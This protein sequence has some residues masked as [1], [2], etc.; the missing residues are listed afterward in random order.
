M[1][2]SSFRTTELSDA[3]FELGNLRFI[4]VKTSNLLGRG[5]ICVYVPPDETL[6]NLPIYILLHGVYGSAWIW[7]FK[8][9]AHHTA[10]RLIAAGE[11]RPAI[12]AMPSDGLWGDGSAYLT[13][14]QKNFASWIV[15]DV[16]K[17]VRELIP[18]AGPNSPLCIGG[19]SMGGFGALMLGGMHPEKFKAVSAHSSITAFHQMSQF[20]NEP[21]STYQIEDTSGDVFSIWQKLNGNYPKLRFD[22]GTS[23]TLLQ[24]NQLLHQQLTHEGIAHDYQEFSGSHEWPYW[25]EHLEKSL[26]F[27]DQQL[28]P[29]PPAW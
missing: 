3:E 28:T 8:G 5:D 23:D 24:A 25:I 4:T 10:N 17:A 11:I 14:H 7:A 2:K 29:A 12:L 9:G 20:V 22:C 19:L 16:P 21:L 18:Q 15:D 13:H 26:I 27:F 6:S 1:K